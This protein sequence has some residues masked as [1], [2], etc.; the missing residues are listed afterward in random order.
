MPP[1]L[2]CRLLLCRLSGEDGIVIGT[3][4]SSRPANTENLM[5]YFLNVSPPPWPQALAC[6][7]GFRAANTCTSC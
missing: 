4:Q 6:S 7:V 1:G 3:T 2:H 5:G